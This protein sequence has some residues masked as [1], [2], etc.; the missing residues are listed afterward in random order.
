LG[1]ANA[2]VGVVGLADARADVVEEL[3]PISHPFDIQVVV[4]PIY[5]YMNIYLNNSQKEKNIFHFCFCVIQ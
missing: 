3:F 2:A 4:L 5:I 1:S